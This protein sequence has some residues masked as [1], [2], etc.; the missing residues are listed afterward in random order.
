MHHSLSPYPAIP[1]MHNN[2]PYQDPVTHH[3]APSLGDPESGNKNKNKN[4]DKDK[5]TVPNRDR[6][7]KVINS[8][9]FI[10]KLNSL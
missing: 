6:V 9:Q 2:F 8:G 1:V 7:F 10:S 5:D 3:F 4:K